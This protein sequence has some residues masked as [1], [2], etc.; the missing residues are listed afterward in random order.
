[1]QQMSLTLLQR[2]S[3]A[4]TVTDCSHLLAGP[5]WL[6]YRG[7]HPH[8]NFEIRDTILQIWKDETKAGVQKLPLT[9][10][11]QRLAVGFHFSGEQ[12]SATPFERPALI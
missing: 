10:L 3:R 8:H 6:L 4:D 9:C 1:M 2:E 12:L 11:P 7:F 5:R